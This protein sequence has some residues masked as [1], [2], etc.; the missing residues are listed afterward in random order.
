MKMPSAVG[1]T[2]QNAYPD[3]LWQLVQWQIMNF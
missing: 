1:T 2:V 3:K